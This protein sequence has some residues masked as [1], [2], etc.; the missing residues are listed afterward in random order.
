MVFFW[1]AAGCQPQRPP[2][3]RALDS[4]PESAP[5]TEPDLEEPLAT[6]TPVLASEHAIILEDQSSISLPPTL[7]LD[8]LEFVFPAFDTQTISLWRPPLYPLPWE[9]TP[10]DH[11][12]FTRPIGA[13]DVNWP[14]ARYRYGYLLY[15]EPHTGIDIPAPK[16]T[17]ILA[18][19]SGTVIHAGYGLYFVQDIYKDPYGIAVAIKHDFGFKG[20]VLYTVYGHLDRVDVYRGQRVNAGDV[21]GVVGETGKVSGPHLHFEVRIGDNTFFS[22]RNPELWIAPPVGWGMLVGQVVESNGRRIPQLKVRLVSLENR[23][24]FE[25]ITYA[26]GSVNSD[27][28]YSE[29]LVLGDIPEGKYLLYL[30]FKD[31][32]VKTEIDIKAGQANYFSYRS[33]RGFDFTRPASKG[34]QFTPPEPLDPTIEAIP[35]TGS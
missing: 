18:A 30:D 23:Q 26:Q 35:E 14:L 34:V 10:E 20:K 24:V 25:A 21:I 2:T 19:G 7:E 15:S 17:P 32:T 29:N 5:I 9:P 8:P 13:N 33:T 3:D 16:M 27:A 31:Q 28:Y 12:Y 11:F 6:P 22:S 4:T 1:G